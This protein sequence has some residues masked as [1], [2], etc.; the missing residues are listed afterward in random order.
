MRQSLSSI[1]IIILSVS[2]GGRNLSHCRRK[3]ALIP[4]SLNRR[5]NVSERVNKYEY[6][7]LYSPSIG[8]IASVVEVVFGRSFR[9]T[10]GTANADALCRTTREE[11]TVSVLVFMVLINNSI[12]MAYVHLP[13]NLTPMYM[14]YSLRMPGMEH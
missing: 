1:Y 10:G 4:S 8:F 3:H 12:A 2:V 13:H 14:M 7:T 9:A 11:I 5:V 6:I